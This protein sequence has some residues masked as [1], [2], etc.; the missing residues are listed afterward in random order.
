MKRNLISF[1]VL[2]A[3]GIAIA[4][5]VAYNNRDMGYPV[6][7]LLSDG[8]FVAGVLIFGSGVIGFAANKGTFDMMGYGIKVAAAPV[9]SW[10][11]PPDSD[12]GKKESFM[13][14]RERKDSQR[15][16]PK[17]LLLSG[18]VLLVLALLFYAAYYLFPV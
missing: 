7:Q 8:F 13:E 2:L 3:L 5:M 11:L 18:L 12:F 4:A 10:M 15:K 6:T 17:P 9:I 14:Y 16:S 1:L